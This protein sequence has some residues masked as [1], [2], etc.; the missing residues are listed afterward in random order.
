M[1]RLRSALLGDA[2]KANC[3]HVVSRVVNRELV[4]GDME[5]ERFLKILRKQLEFSGVECLSWCVMGNH[6]HLLLRVPDKETALE[7]WT[8]EAYI[9]RLGVLSEEKYTHQLLGNVKMWQGN[10]CEHLVTELA[11]RVRNRLFDLSSFMKEV[12]QKFSAWFNLTHGRTGTLWED[13]FRSVLVE[14]T[15][16]Y[17]ADGL[18]GLL[19]VAA[20]IDLNPARAGI[21]DDPKNYRWGSYAAAVAGDK[22]ARLGIGVCFGAAKK[23]TWRSVGAGYRKLL[24]GAGAE[25][26]G[27]VTADGKTR[28][29]RG[30]TQKE[31]EAVWKAGGKL[32][33]A[34]VLRCR[35][36]YFTEGIALGGQQFLRSWGEGSDSIRRTAKSVGGADL[37]G[38]MFLG[39]KNEN[40]IQ[41]P[42]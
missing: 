31:I 30:F 22:T 40:A 12:K 9:A 18:S 8:E 41:A 19:A 11:G 28:S 24:F 10:G 6:F 2:P 17:S 14:G 29:R 35:V 13:R 4:F 36:T 33:L 20:Y 7:G 38:L 23:A 3:Y 16:G 15:G 21:V 34:Q 26:I 1:R 32:T 42:G 25:E 37:G 39:S 27:G 5:K